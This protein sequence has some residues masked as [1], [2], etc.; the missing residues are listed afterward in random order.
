MAT[1]DDDEEGDQRRLCVAC[2]EEPFL[3]ALI[4]KEGS[5]ASCDFCERRRGRTVTLEVMADKVEQAFADHYRQTSDQPDP[6][7]EIAQRYGGR[8]WTRHGE[9]IDEAIQLAAGIDPEPANAIVEILAERHNTMAP[10]DPDYEQEFDPE[11]HY[12]RLRIAE[13]DHFHRDW[14]R[15]EQSLKSETR[16]FS[17]SAQAVLGEI[18]DDIAMLRT[19]QNGSVIFV[20]GPGSP[21]TS[22]YRARVFQSED[23]LQAALE[24]PDLEIAPPPSVFAR[25]GRMNARGVPVFYGATDERIAM[26]EVRPPVGADVIVARFELTR[27]LRL[28]DVAALGTVFV[29]GSIFD[30]TLASR[31]KR[32]LF[33]QTLSAKIVRPVM[34]DSEDFEYLV[35][36]AMA[37]YLA[38][39]PG[40]QLDGILFPS[41]QSRSK[42][43][44]VVLF[45]KAARAAL[46][47]L[48]AGSEVRARFYDGYWDEDPNDTP[49][50]WT[51]TE[52]LPPPEVRK[53]AAAD[54]FE[55][56]ASHFTGSWFDDEDTDRRQISLRLD[57]KSLVVHRVAS[58]RF[59]TT[60]TPVVRIRA[61]EGDA[62]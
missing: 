17:R 9:L 43:S 16:F 53:G 29:E 20:A 62:L 36:Q 10:G 25:A 56:V 24:R 2:V 54:P 57:P 32:A 50:S 40:L 8:S 11:S 47:D 15:F 23:K 59:T 49:P 12:E 4:R 38:D 27:P 60:T 48:P 18:F 51:V 44:N 7:E 1:I 35:T 52:V 6:M 55:S 39:H 30:P 31:Q 45:H 33:L 13:D 42:G 19:K 22:L 61:D 58:V 34:P 5:V 21:M 28:L 41:V 26:A 46:F 37:D 14:E 3:K